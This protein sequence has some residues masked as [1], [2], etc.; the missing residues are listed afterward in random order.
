M[1]QMKPTPAFL[2]ASGAGSRNKGVI[3]SYLFPHTPFRS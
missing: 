2:L 1:P 3:D